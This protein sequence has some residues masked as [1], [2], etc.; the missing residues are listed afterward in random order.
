MLC[1]D[2]FATRCGARSSSPT[3]EQEGICRPTGKTLIQQ[4]VQ[5]RV[6]RAERLD[7][8]DYIGVHALRHTFCSH[9]AM[10]GAP[11]KA[12][13]ELAGHPELI[14]TQRYMHFSPAVLESAIRLLEGSPAA[15]V[16]D[17]NREE[18]EH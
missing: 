1:A 13:Q 7:N 4:E 6:L 16:K 8:L 14:T 9:L 2:D 17:A 3:P 18:V 11:A 5:R 12:I 10:R 15:S